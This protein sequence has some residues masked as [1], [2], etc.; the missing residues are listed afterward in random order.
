MS[1]LKEPL[2]TISCYYEYENTIVDS[3]EINAIDE[4]EVKRIVINE[5]WF[6]KQV[7]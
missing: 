1:N 6:I 7:K 4:N 3:E 2:D 5:D